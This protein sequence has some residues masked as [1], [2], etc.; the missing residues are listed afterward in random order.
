[1]KSAAI[2]LATLSATVISSPILTPAPEPT[3]MLAILKQPS[4][5]SDCTFHAKTRTKTVYTDC[6]GCGLETK[7]L[8]LGLPCR[9]LTTIPGVAYETV[10]SCCSEKPAPTLPGHK[11]TAI[12]TLPGHKVTALPTPSS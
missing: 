8:G 5:E 1:M 2:I 10:T 7:M 6:G 12:P 4:F 9:T 3:C 11:V